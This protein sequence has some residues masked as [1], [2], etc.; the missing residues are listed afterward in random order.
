MDFVPAIIDFKDDSLQSTLS[1]CHPRNDDMAVALLEVGNTL[2]GFA[3]GV[4]CLPDDGK[5]HFII[6]VGQSQ[7]HG[8]PMRAVFKEGFLVFKKKNKKKKKEKK[9]LNL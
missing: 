7:V 8:L 4:S 5:G 3:I 2:Q 9:K 1:I 6:C